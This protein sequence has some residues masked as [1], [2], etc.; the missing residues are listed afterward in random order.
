MEKMPS[1]ER[2]LVTINKNKRVKKKFSECKLP[3][4][5]VDLTSF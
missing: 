2:E 3:S 5:S 4:L 1:A